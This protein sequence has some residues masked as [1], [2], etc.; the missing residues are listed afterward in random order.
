MNNAPKVLCV[1]FDKTLA[2]PVDFPY[3]MKATW[4]NKLVWK[5]VRFMKKRGY[6][7]ILNT[8]REREKGLSEALEFCRKN[9]IPIDYANENLQSE[10]EK[11][12]DSRK[13]ACT[14]FI[15]DR[16]VGFI[17]WLLRKFG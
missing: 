16:Q 6:I 4:L 14:Y 8:L 7:I 3:V 5:Y 9:N 12:G 1:D 11:W 10:I 13:L 2:R 15:D 17:G